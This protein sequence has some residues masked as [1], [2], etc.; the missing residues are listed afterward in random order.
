MTSL[1]ISDLHLCAERPAITKL[2][3]EF[4]QTRAAA[5]QALY[6][7]GDLMEYWIGDEAMALPEHQGI[8]QGLQQLTANGVLVS[9]M[10][11]NRDFLLGQ[12]FMQQSGCRLLPDPSLIELD[13][14]MVLLMHGDSLCTDDV[15]YIAF[16][17]MVRDPA[18]QQKVLAMAVPE[19][20][21]LSR[22]LREDSK[23]AMA[24]KK[25][26]IMDVNQQAVEQVMRQHG[27]RQ[28]IHGHTHRPAVHHFELDGATVTRTVLGDWYEQ[29]SVLRVQPGQWV[30]ENLPLNQHPEA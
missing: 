12:A 10:H 22:Q 15:D 25:P 17:K 1:F 5:A 14:Q 27:V 4:L 29:G 16:R 24:G 23:V 6:I 9:I 21:A 3:L 11:G 30:L 2:F 20:I 13:G 8:V 26:E 19:R 28:L 18:W 7:L